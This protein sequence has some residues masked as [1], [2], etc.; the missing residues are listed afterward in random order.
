MSDLPSA[1]AAPE[2]RVIERRP[3]G[4]L[5]Y[6]VTMPAGSG[7]DDPARLVVWLHPTGGLYHDRAEALA[8]AFI[9][10]GFALMVILDKD[11]RGW[12]FDDARILLG[13]TLPD[14]GAIEG[15]DLR[16]PLLF[17][18]SA[19]GQV[20]LELWRTKPALYGGII[21]N[22]AYPAE[23]QDGKDVLL[24]PPSDPAIRDV[25]LL[26]LVGERDR[27]LWVWENIRQPW[28]EAGVPL[29]VVVVP[30]KGHEW[31]FGDA[32]VESLE[33]WLSHLPAPRD[34]V[35]APPQEEPAP[36]VHP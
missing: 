8:P 21:V 3:D 10:H 11:S 23:T 28:I 4:G 22:A 7:T 30:G 12:T 2:I 6:R 35:V 32:Q 27:L 33:D 25:P 18:F 9:R 14:V 31:L 1:K 16:R 19:G 29:T 5:A 13:T 15:I 34:Q 17:G 20:A 24:G 26:V 36:A